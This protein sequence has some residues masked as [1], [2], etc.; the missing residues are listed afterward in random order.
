M[1]KTLMFLVV[2]TLILTGCGGNKYPEFL[3]EKSWEYDN[4]TCAESIRFGEDGEFIYSEA[5]GSPVGNYDLY[6][7]YKYNEKDQTITL[8]PCEGGFDKE[9][10]QVVEYSDSSL[11]LKFQDGKVKEFRTDQDIPD[12]PEKYMDYIEGFTGYKSVYKLEDNK[13][14]IGPSGFDGD[15]DGKDVFKP[16][17]LASD[18]KLHSLDVKTIIKG[19]AEKSTYN[20]EVLTKEEAFYN[21]DNSVRIGFVWLNENLEVEEILYFGELI[22]WE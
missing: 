5:C 12:V 14:Y 13:V 20:Y 15:V 22:I 19:D 7:E 6:D 17:E 8:I 11:I 21:P 4:K 1:K 3:T 16:Y 18:A 2:L 9:T 10:I